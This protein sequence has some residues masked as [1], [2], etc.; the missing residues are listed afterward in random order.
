MAG[1]VRFPQGSVLFLKHSAAGTWPPGGDRQLWQRLGPKERPLGPQLGPCSHTCLTA[2]APFPTWPVETGL[3]ARKPEVCLISSVNLASADACWPY[4]RFVADGFG[5]GV[6]YSS[7]SQ[8]STAGE[9]S[10]HL[11]PH[12]TRF[13]LSGAKSQCQASQDSDLLGM[14]FKMKSVFT[15]GRLGILPYPTGLS[16]E[17]RT[18]EALCTLSE[19]INNVASATMQLLSEL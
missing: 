17:S 14:F 10:C 4:P 2:T 13:I 5:G 3:K 8:A 15:E 12:Q 9:P 18:R 6:S 1:R 16:R 11:W 7:E 19:V